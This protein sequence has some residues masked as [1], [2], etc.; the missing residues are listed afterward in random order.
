MLTKFISILV[1]FLISSLFHVSASDDEMLEHYMAQCNAP[2]ALY[3][4]EVMANTLAEPDKFLQLLEIMSTPVTAMTVYECIAN[5]EQRQTV[6][7]T[8]S[9]P[10]KL[11]ASMSTFMSPQMYMNWMTAMQNPETQQAL[12]TYMN[13]EHFRQW[14]NSVFELGAQHYSLKNN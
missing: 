5:E 12:T 7:K 1:I 8:M 2:A 11:A 13:P 3:D 14:M 4:P 9:D 10:G 6:I